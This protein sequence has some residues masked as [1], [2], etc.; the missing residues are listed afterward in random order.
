MTSTAETGLTP[1]AETADAP[2]SVALQR[3]TAVA[4]ERA[5]NSGF[6]SRLL[7]GES[8]ADALVA[9]L[10][11]SLPVY[12]ALEAA[13]ARNASDPRLAPLVDARLERTAALRA[14]LDAHRAAGHAIAEPLPATQ[15][16]VD[17]LVACADSPAALIGHHYTRYLGDL[18]GGQIIATL[19]RRHYDA[20]DDVLTFYRFDIDKPKTYK[21]GYR[22]RLDAL[23]LDPAEQDEALD[24]ASRAFALNAAVFDALDACYPAGSTA[25]AEAV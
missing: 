12:A 2:L 11:Q 20:P 23:R 14:D 21:D 9:L 8:N 5:E 24:A 19:M 1:T 7:G 10:A 15:R 6:M 22:A 16:Y 17:D 25:R 3:S 18:S 13:V 4:H